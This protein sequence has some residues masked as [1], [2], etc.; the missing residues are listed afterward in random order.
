MLLAIAGSC[1][2]AALPW[3]LSALH[4]DEPINLTLAIEIADISC[5][6]MGWSAI[7][8]DAGGPIH[9]AEINS[10]P[11]GCNTWPLDNTSHGIHS[12]TICIILFL[13][14]L[15]GQHTVFVSIHLA[16]WKYVGGSFDSSDR[17]ALARLGLVLFFLKVPNSGALASRGN[18]FRFIRS[19]HLELST[20][21]SFAFKGEPCVLKGLQS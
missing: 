2:P 8:S 4:L 14:F 13:I 10:Q 17:P 6:N 7:S 16:W 11:R 21:F 15:S 12:C 5:F 18:V 3:L 1:V 9:G 20:W 19:A